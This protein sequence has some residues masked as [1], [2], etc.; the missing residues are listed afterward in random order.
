MSMAKDI[1]IISLPNC[2]KCDEIKAYLKE[3]KIPFTDRMLDSELQTELVM[4]NVYSN[5]PNVRVDGK[6]YTH[7]DFL[8][9]PEL[10]FGVESCDCSEGCSC[11]QK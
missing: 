2:S 4:E 1:L 8:A 6:Y 11:C 10:M 5:P 3:N 9:N 7:K